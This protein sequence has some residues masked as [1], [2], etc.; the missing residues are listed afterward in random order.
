MTYL[1]AMNKTIDRIQALLEKGL[2]K[3]LKGELDKT[4]KNL[5]ELAIAAADHTPTSEVMKKK[6]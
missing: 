6:S 5:R 4:L 2:P 1:L 3:D